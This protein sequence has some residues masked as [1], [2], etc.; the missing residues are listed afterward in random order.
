MAF[1][2]EAVR[3]DPTLVSSSAPTVHGRCGMSHQQARILGGSRPS[4]SYSRPRSWPCIPS[5][6][7]TR[8]RR[9]T[10]FIEAAPTGSGKLTTVTLFVTD[11][12][13]DVRHES[14]PSFRLASL[15]LK[16][17]RHVQLVAH[18]DPEGTFPMSIAAARVD[19]L[20][21]AEQAGAAIP[22]SGYIYL[23][24]KQPDG[25]RFI[26]GAQARPVL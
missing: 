22:D 20:A 16:G 17:G 14:E 15:Q 21:R 1:T 2:E 10:V 7:R 26:I 23:F 5:N 6:G 12:D 3:K 18:A 13:L 19:V 24:G 9:D 8:L 11:G 4:T 25:A